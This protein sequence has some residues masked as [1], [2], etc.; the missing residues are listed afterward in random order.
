[1]GEGLKQYLRHPSAAVTRVRIQQLRRADRREHYDDRT[2]L[3]KLYAIKFG[4]K[5]NLE[6][7]ETFS[8][9]LQ[10]LKLYDRRPEY[11]RMVDKYEAKGYAAERIGE[12]YIIPTL[13]VW[14]HFDEIPFDELPDRFVLKCTHDSGGLRIC[15]DKATFDFDEARERLEHCLGRSYFRNNREWPYKNVNPRILAEQYMEDSDGKGEL[16]DYKLHFFGGECRAV[17]VAQNR[18]GKGGLYKD[19]YTPEWGHMDFTRGD[20]PNA[21][22]RVPRPEQLDDMIRLGKKLAG[23]Y[24]FIRTDFYVINGDIYFG[25]MTFFPGSGTLR[26]HPDRWDRVFGEWIQLP[27]KR[28]EKSGAEAPE[29]TGKG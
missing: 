29:G 20:G 14:D 6:N 28:T 23:D 3:E 1:M 24:P 17:L 13:G 15:R 12:E 11:T 4:K 26:F 8:E 2:F 9:K 19:F 22:S 10:W 16:T 18:F 27:E 7:P 25:E 5:P 21:P